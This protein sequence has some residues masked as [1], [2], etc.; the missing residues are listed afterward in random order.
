M[1][2]TGVASPI[3]A[4]SLPSQVI[5]ATPVIDFTSTPISL[6]FEEGMTTGYFN[7]TLIDN[8]L[9]SPLKVF[10]FSLTSV[11]PTS[12]SETMLQS[13]RLSSVNTTARITIIDDEGGAGQFQLNPTTATVAEGST[14]TFSIL[15]L[16][17]TS[18]SISV[19][20]Q[21]L[22]SGLATSGADFQPISQ[23]LTFED[24]ISQLLQSVDIIDDSVPEGP[25]DFM[26][27]LS[28]PSGDTLVDSNAVSCW[29][30]NDVQQLYF[31]SHRTPYKLLLK[32]VITLLVFSHSSLH[33]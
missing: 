20:L 19:L 13:P 6:T 25:E 28:V 4:S 12:N 21:T 5:S 32:P 24:G 8:S 22:D 16:G 11:V 17:G 31:N 7:I 30:D 18:G 9:T 3:P 2:V 1:I 23:L 15:R 14:L 10:V 29:H 33:H 26:V 27:T